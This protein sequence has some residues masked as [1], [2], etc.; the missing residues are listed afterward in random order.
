MALPLDLAWEPDAQRRDFQSVLPSRSWSECWLHGSG[1]GRPPPDAGY[2]A[3]LNPV[4]QETPRSFAANIS[5]EFAR[6]GQNVSARIPRQPREDATRTSTRSL[7][8]EFNKSDTALVVI[9]PQNDVLSKT[10]DRHWAVEP[11][12]PLPRAAERL[13]D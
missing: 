4:R 2:A 5:G 6:L 7:E 9:D 10:K 3:S 1:P 11:T 8:M 12:S 13:A